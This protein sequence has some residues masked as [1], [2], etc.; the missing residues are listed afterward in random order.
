MQVVFICIP[1]FRLDEELMGISSCESME[2]ILDRRAVS[3]AYSLYPAGEERRLV[4]TALKYLVDL[5][6]GMYNVAV[7][8]PS[9]PLY[10]GKSRQV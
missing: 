4:K 10:R 5:F 1:P 8:L 2:F 7:A 9:G 6:I 3:R